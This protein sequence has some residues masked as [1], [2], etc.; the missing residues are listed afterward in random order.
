MSAPIPG[1]VCCQ[2]SFTCGS[3]S[4]PKANLTIS[5]VNT[6]T[7]NGS[8]TMVWDGVNS[9]NSGCTGGGSNQ[10][11]F[12]LLCTTGFVELRAFYMLS[13]SCPTGD[14]NYCS[15]GRASPN[16]LTETGLT[17]GASFL[18]TC[19]TENCNSLSANGFTDFTV[20]A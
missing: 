18:L 2:S 3:C 9:W 17:C 10:H 12:T 14:S 20:S 1:C 7:G 16:G 19:T 11:I 5:W 8:D 4:V 15:T 6:I 13:G